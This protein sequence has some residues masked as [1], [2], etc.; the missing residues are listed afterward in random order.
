MFTANTSGKVYVYR[1]LSIAEKCIIN[2]NGNIQARSLDIKSGDT[3]L[4]KVDSSGNATLYKNVIIGGKT[5]FM[6]VIRGQG[7]TTTSNGD[8]ITQGRLWL[9]GL[10]RTGYAGKWKCRITVNGDG[11]VVTDHWTQI[12]E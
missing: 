11:M 3:N 7:F 6:D 8:I 10:S 12:E 5:T 2:D 1:E 4:F 9:T